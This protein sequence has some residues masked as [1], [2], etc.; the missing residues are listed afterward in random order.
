[1]AQRNNGNRSLQSSNQL[2]RSALPNNVGLHTLGD[3]SR[4]YP[5]N[6]GQAVPL[7]NSYLQNPV[8]GPNPVLMN[9][10]PLPPRPSS[11]MSNYNRY[12][13]MSNYFSPYSRYG[14]SNYR[15]PPYGHFGVRGD[16]YNSF[17]Q[18][19][20]EST[21]PAF[22]SIES[23]VEVVSSISM[24][25]ESTYHAV[26]SSYSAILGV[27]DQFSRLKDHFAEVLSVL[28][29]IRG[30]RW[31]CLKVLYLLR[32]RKENP[33]VEA[34]WFSAKKSANSLEM[35]GEVRGTAWPFFMFLS[36]VIGAPW[37]MF[38]LLSKNISKKKPFDHRLFVNSNG[39]YLFCYAAFD[40]NATQPNE[41]TIRSGEKLYVSPKN[42][43][44][45]DKWVFA[46]NEKYET[47]L[48]PVNY[49]KNAAYFPKKKQH[50]P[51]N[52][53]LDQAASA[54]N[55][56][57]E[58]ATAENN[59]ALGE[60]FPSSNIV[61]DHTAAENIVSGEAIPSSDIV[62]E[63]TI[64]KSNIPSN[65]IVTKNNIVPHQTINEQTEVMNTF[66]DDVKTT[67][68]IH[69]VIEKFPKSITVES[70]KSD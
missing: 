65:Q 60:V 69:S 16:A 29:L 66:D 64:T 34:A 39:K 1:M 46:A 49:L 67:E 26:H 14:M 5:G 48:V 58:E 36:L 63:E 50:I 15:M 25:L 59:C 52:N 55:F 70:H 38:K 6:H 32:L 54:D 20:E 12:P 9:A 17:V 8:P 45:K 33:S 61:P 42:I 31:L 3:F 27:V 35:P 30:L 44:N 21:R 56:V 13:G 43:Q 57:A 24:M 68:K 11:Y 53:T 10:P 28:S 18:M 47:G 40:F 51:K 7:P 22:E 19:A 41:L 4:I 2:H 23:V 37:L 62:P